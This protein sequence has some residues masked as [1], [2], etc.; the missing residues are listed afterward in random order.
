MNKNLLKS[1]IVAHGDSLRELADYLGITASTLSK[2][3][4]EKHKAGFNQ[5]EIMMIKKR[6]CLSADEVDAIFFWSIVS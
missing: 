2:K 4:N 3:I 5:P 1:V 6:Y